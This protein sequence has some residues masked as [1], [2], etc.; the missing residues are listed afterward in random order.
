MHLHSQVWG[1]FAI[2]FK[3]LQVSP[4]HYIHMD[5][6]TLPCT[7][8]DL[9]TYSHSMPQMNLKNSYDQTPEAFFD[10]HTLGSG[11][12]CTGNSPNG[13]LFC[14]VSHMSNQGAWPTSLSWGCS[15]SSE[16]IL[17]V[18]RGIVRHC[19]QLRRTGE[20]VPLPS[21]SSQASHH[22]PQRKHNRD[23]V[24]LLAMKG[25]SRC[26]CVAS[27]GY[28][29]YRQVQRMLWLPSGRQTQHQWEI[30]LQRLYLSVLWGSLVSYQLSLV[31][32]C[33]LKGHLGLMDS[34][35]LERVRMGCSLAEMD[36]PCVQANETCP[37]TFSSST[38]PLLSSSAPILSIA[39]W[40]GIRISETFLLVG[41]PAGNMP[42]AIKLLHMAASLSKHWLMVSIW[43][44][45][46]YLLEQCH[47]F[48]TTVM[49]RDLVIDKHS[50]PG[51]PKSSMWQR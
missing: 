38:G 19:I 25:W 1:L 34:C 4:S 9:C 50:P 15:L 29:L 45:A 8:D 44:S 36:V 32:L 42:C 37:S 13:R 28:H 7:N 26:T 30:D 20:C 17:P 51:A 3:L 2:L 39:A 40:C 27:H 12:L 11:V 49:W 5:F 33:E 23:V 43:P 22:P 6:R 21:H 31:H 16:T 46:W 47:G 14:P 24:Y 48:F 35:V 10:H 18:C 41:C